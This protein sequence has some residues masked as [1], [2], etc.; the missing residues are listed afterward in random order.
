LL[1]SLPMVISTD[2]NLFLRGFNKLRVFYI[3]IV[4]RK[5]VFAGGHFQTNFVRKCRRFDESVRYLVS[6][7][8]DFTVQTE[9]LLEHD[10][11]ETEEKP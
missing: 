5:H 4:R 2:A 10:V 1:S 9:L 6:F 7:W 8:F 3:N 11:S